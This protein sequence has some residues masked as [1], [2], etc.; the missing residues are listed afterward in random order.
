MPVMDWFW[1]PILSSLATNLEVFHGLTIIRDT[2]HTFA[3][4]CA[5]VLVSP[6]RFI[7]IGFLL[8]IK[9]C[10]LEQNSVEDIGRDTIGKQPVKKRLFLPRL[11]VPPWVIDC[12][13]CSLSSIL[14]APPCV[15]W[16]QEQAYDC[17]CL[18]RY[19][20]FCLC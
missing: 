16:Q 4:Q 7:L 19:N 20:C 15:C 10:M 8:V 11:V 1:W 9:M 2:Q 17:T 3:Q 14:K 6:V 5:E 13:T 12:N 18:W